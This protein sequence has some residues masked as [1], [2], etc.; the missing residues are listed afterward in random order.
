MWTGRISCRGVS[1]NREKD[2]LTTIKQSALLLLCG[3]KRQKKDN[4]ETLGV[5]TDALFLIPSGERRVRG[6]EG[7][8]R[9][10]CC[11]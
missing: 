9:C 2:V 1:D 8:F 3:N 7:T 10:G 11:H 5:K 4:E 6:G